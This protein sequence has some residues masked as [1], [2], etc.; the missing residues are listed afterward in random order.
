MSV[1]KSEQYQSNSKFIVNQSSIEILKSILN[2]TDNV[3]NVYYN[4]DN[5]FVKFEIEKNNNNIKIICKCLEG[6]FINYK[7]IIPDEYY[8][9]SIV[10]A[11]DIQEELEFIME[12][13][14]RGVMKTVFTEGKITLKGNQCKEGYSE[15]KSNRYQKEKQKILDEKYTD[16]MK[17][18]R[19]KKSKAQK[20]NKPF[21]TKE[22][23][24]K[25]AKFKKMYDLIPVSDI[26]SEINA[27][28]KLKDEEFIIAYNPKYMIDA[29]KQYKDNVEI[30]MTTRVSPLVVSEDAEN[31]ELILPIRI[32]A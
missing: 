3:V 14:Q 9:R 23:E 22:P 29:M 19:E 20:N 25:F 27:E 16:K 1:R 24:K 18:W 26:I 21:T 12:A 30:R 28:N 15:E 6:D 32:N 31:L 13:D 2:N 7:Q 10:K 4:N 8:N 5:K 17:E 11:L